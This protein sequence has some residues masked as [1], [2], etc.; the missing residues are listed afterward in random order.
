MLIFSGDNKGTQPGYDD[1]RGGTIVEA[2]GVVSLHAGQAVVKP[3]SI[4]I[5]G[6]TRSPGG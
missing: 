4:R 2:R 6:H 3:V 1:L 5:V